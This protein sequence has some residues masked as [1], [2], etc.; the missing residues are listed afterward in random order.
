[1]F[2]ELNS[3]LNTSPDSFTQVGIS[4]SDLLTLVVCADGNMLLSKT[5]QGEFILVS[6]RRGDASFLI[7]HFLCFYLRGEFTFI[8]TFSY[9]RWWWFRTEGNGRLMH[10]RFAEGFCF[11]SARCRVLFLGLVQ[12]LNHYSSVSQRLVSKRWFHFIYYS[13]LQPIK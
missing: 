1:M 3:I 2:P 7:H 10:M 5:L 4:T 13:V 8:T 11:I 9:R 6:D 12:T